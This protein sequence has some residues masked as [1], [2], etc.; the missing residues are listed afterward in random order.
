MPSLNDLAVVVVVVVTFAGRKFL[1]QPVDRRRRGGD[2]LVDPGLHGGLE[3][4]ERP[5]DQDLEGQSGILR[6]L[7]DPDRGLME[8]QVAA[9]GQLTDEIAVPD[10]ALDEFDPGIGQGA[11]QIGPTAPHEVVQDANSADIGL[12]QLV[13]DG[14]TDRSGSARHQ[15]RSPPQGSHATLQQ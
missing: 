3:Y 4:V 12:Q 10:V 2:D 7:G 13:D 14:G 1:G 15:R 6:A 8:H 9:R 11:G 5:V